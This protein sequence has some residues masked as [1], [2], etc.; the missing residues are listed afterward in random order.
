MT[1][2]PPEPMIDPA[3]LRLSKSTGRSKRSGRYATA[4]RA[5]GLHGLDLAPCPAGRRRCRVTTSPMV[6]PSGNLDET[7][8]ADL[9]NQREDLGTGVSGHADL[10]VLGG[11]AIDDNPNVGEGLDVVDYRSGSHQCPARWGRGAVAS[12]PP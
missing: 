6:I 3:S 8:V 10:G 12:A 7:R 9:S 11:A 4:R 2:M 1:I 5:A